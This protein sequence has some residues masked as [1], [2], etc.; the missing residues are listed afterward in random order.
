MKRATVLA[1]GKGTNAM[2]IAS[3][4]PRSMHPRVETTAIQT[5]VQR[6]VRNNSEEKTSA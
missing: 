6:A 1:P 2:I 3:T 5:V 4:N